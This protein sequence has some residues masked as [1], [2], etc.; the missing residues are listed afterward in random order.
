M[1]TDAINDEILRIKREL[2]SAHGNDVARIAAD[3]RSRQAS[4][5]SHEPRRIKS[6][7]NSQREAKTPALP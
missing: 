3:A 2:S 5:V 7:Q 4:V 6:E 1:I